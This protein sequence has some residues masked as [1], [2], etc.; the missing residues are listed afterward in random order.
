MEI[1][2]LGDLKCEFCNG[3]GEKEKNIDGMDCP[4]TCSFCNGSGIDSDQLQK[5]FTERYS[6]NPCSA[7]GCSMG[8]QDYKVL[9]VKWEGGNEN[10]LLEFAGD[11]ISFDDDPSPDF[12]TV[13]TKEGMQKADLG[14]YIVINNDG[15][16]SVIK[17]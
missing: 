6:K 16:F 11:A 15:S 4:C 10:E 9:S 17:E 13:K 7:C 1:I 3:L 14:D 5:L 8:S 2:K 12:V